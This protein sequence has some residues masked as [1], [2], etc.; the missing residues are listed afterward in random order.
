MKFKKWHKITIAIILSISFIIGSLLVSQT[1]WAHKDDYFKP[2][3]KR[4]TLTENSDS[5]T[6]F[7]QTGLGEVVSKKLILEG[8]F[9]EILKAQELFFN[10]P[11]AECN[12]LLSWFT[13][14]DRLKSSATPFYDLQPGDILVTLSTHSI[15]W[16]HGHAGLVIDDYSALECAV[17][18]TNSQIDSISHWNTYSNYAVLRIKNITPEL[19]SKVTA[20][21]HD[22][23][24][25]VPYKLTSGFFG[26]KAPSP[27][28]DDFGLHC[29]YLV[30]YAWQ[31]FGFDLDSDGGPLVT[32]S[33]ILNSDLVEVVQIY[34]MD[35]ND[36]L[37]NF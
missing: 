2:E 26:E 34:G 13:R 35:P 9:N 7:L 31:H 21:A 29:S 18:G 16:R 1:L 5:K 3:Y 25:D 10:G 33:D 24:T 17:L 19:Q 37:N 12:A 4:V 36:F 20:F 27:D 14:E 15:G 23:L 30:W 32:T 11:K 22:K 6:I 8:R 28:S